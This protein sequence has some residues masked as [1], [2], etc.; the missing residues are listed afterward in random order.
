MPIL[1]WYQHLLN[2]TY[3][4]RSVEDVGSDMRA[5]A[6]V[7][8]V[9]ELSGLQQSD[10]VVLRD[11]H[12]LWKVNVQNLMNKIKEAIVDNGFLM[13]V[14]KY[15][16][17]EPEE[18]IDSV[19]CN[20]KK[21]ITNTLLK[22][23]IE[24]L[25]K[26]TEESGLRLIASKSDSVSTLAMMFRRIDEKKTIP[27][28]SEVIEVNAERDEKWFSQIIECLQISKE[29]IDRAE[30]PKPVWLIANDTNVN[31]IVGLVNCLRLEPGGQCIRCLFDMDSN[32][33]L[34]IDWTSKP[35]SDI[36]NNDLVV[37]VIERWKTGNV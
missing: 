11:G 24:S 3:L 29:A 31:G 4:V 6:K 35:F 34:P 26:T 36:L 7:W 8:S 10:L 21:S 19:I 23:R 32:L 37:N 20:G 9:D 16:L 2:I 30:T 12:D 1:S 25:I 22:E 13:I 17:T 14:A 5:N 15:R 27:E 33:K 18:A 28:K